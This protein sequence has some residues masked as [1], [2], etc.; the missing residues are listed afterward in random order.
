M[1]PSNHRSRGAACVVVVFAV[2]ATLAT[3]LGSLSDAHADPIGGIR[4][5]DVSNYQHPGGASIDWAQV[6]GA[7]NRFVFIKA[8]EGPVSPG[9]PYYTN[10]WFK[11]DRSDAAAV[12]M[13]RGAYHFGR[14]QY[15]LDSAIFQARYFVSVTGPMRGAGD[16]PHVLDLEDSGGLPPADLISWTFA[17][18]NELEAL[19]GR[20]PIIYSGW[21]FWN[22]A[23]AGSTAFGDYRLWMAR[24]TSATNPLPLPSGWPTW[25]FW[26][27]SSSLSV[28]GIVGNV[29][30]NV[31]CCEG[32][33]LAALADGTSVSAAASNPFGSFDGASRLPGGVRVHGWAIDPDTTAPITVHV[34]VDGKSVSAV[35]ADRGRSDLVTGY[36]GWGANHGF[37]ATVNVAGPGDHSVC[38]YA[39]NVH[40][41]TSNPRLSCITVL[42]HPVGVIDNVS[43]LKAGTLEVRG[44]A[45]DPDT[46]G[47]IDV[48][49]YV[50]NRGAG[51]QRASLVRRDL[52]EAFV[53]GPNHGFSMVLSAAP[54]L[55][56]VC[57][58]AINVGSG[59]HSQLGCRDVVVLSSIPIGAIDIAEGGASRVYVRGWA[60]DPDADVSIDVHVYVDGVSRGAL[61]ADQVRADVGT[62]FPALGETHGYDGW[63]SFVGT[64]PHTVCV[65]GINVGLGVN[66]LLACK[67]FTVRSGNAF[68]LITAHSTR[69]DRIRV[70]GWAIDPDTVDS[71]SVHVYV[72]GQKVAEVSASSPVMGLTDLFPIYGAGHGY[73]VEVAGIPGGAHNVCVYGINVGLGTNALLECEIIAT[74]GNPFG[75]LDVVVREAGSVT[76]R[77]W[78]ID[79]DT[80]API[81]IHIYVDGIGRAI[82]KAEAVRLDLGD[83]FA[84][85]GPAHGFVTTIPMNEPGAHRVCVYAINVGLGANSTLGCQVV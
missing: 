45:I 31:Y 6:A 84:D 85:Y 83:D 72:D 55:H 41:G 5:I 13:Y 57:V 39:I 67:P 12:G 73:D 37:D 40:G 29:D 10:P 8:T 56:N 38:V 66:A 59:H 19:T 27:Y 17:F 71:I 9:G 53:Y 42:G 78:T 24:Y 32:A 2:L 64:G 63:A 81:T 44:W 61:K 75:S 58:Y 33:N 18:L 15:P 30:G 47:P 21:Y 68:G 43:H 60:L 7:G 82:V 14:P 49:V 35:N 11:R 65:H 62:T 80:N 22:T 4:G 46:T 51:I 79:P 28:L 48:H 74:T 70:H 54:G 25:T 16:L 20:R 23:L 34:Y 3:T 26:Q 50:D 1:T 36:P 76:A 69:L 52:A 77:G